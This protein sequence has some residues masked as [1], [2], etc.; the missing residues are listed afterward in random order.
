MCVFL[1]STYLFSLSL[2]LLG[3]QAGA[4]EAKL[5]SL[6]MRRAAGIFFKQ[7]LQTGRGRESL[8]RTTFIGHRV[9]FTAGAN[10]SPAPR[11]LVSSKQAEGEIENGE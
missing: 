8:L 9:T 11:I 5:L 2:I 10:T 7:R 4:C 3:G 6:Q 1:S